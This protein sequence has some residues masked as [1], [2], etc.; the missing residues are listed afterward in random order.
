[1]INI[2]LQSPHT[3]ETRSIRAASMVSDHIHVTDSTLAGL[4]QHIRQLADG[5]MPVGSVEFVRESMRLAGLVEPQ[6]L[7]YTN[8]TQLYLHRM[9]SKRNAGEVIGQVFVKPVE[10][11]L[12]NG[13]VFDTMQDRSQYSE[14]DQA[15]YDAFMTLAASEKVFVSD[16]VQWE[17]EWRYYV[18]NNQIIGQ[19][20]YDQT[21]CEVAP[22]PDVSKVE[23]CIKDLA[24]GHPYAL[25]FGVLSS[26]E[27]ALVEVNDAWAIGLYGHALPPCTYLA[28][29]Q[30]RWAQIYGQKFNT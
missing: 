4:R 18:A 29:L 3:F 28:F 16:P 2:I 12:F 20:R 9:V 11:K 15:Q 1:M 22:V 27:T 19:A 30:E 24:L 14:H 26:G 10:T 6:N 7:S 8:G 13:F 23:S 17:S 21:E 25:D 5:A